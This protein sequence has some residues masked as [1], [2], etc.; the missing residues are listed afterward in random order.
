MVGMPPY[1]TLGITRFTVGGNEPI[2]LWKSLDCVIN[3]HHSSLSAPLSV[4]SPVLTGFDRLGLPV[5]APATR[6]TVGL[7][8][9]R[10]ELLVFSS[11]SVTFCQF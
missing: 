11:L 7:A 10:P 3:V 4:I 6:F 8:Y 9:F 1:Y 2:P 5:W